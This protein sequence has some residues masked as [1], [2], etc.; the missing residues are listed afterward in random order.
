MELNLYALKTFKEVVDQQGFSH[1]AKVLFL[2]QPAV[3][4]Q[5][6]SLESYFQTP[7]LIRGHA[8]K[9]QMTQEGEILYEYASRLE[10]IQHELSKRM[11]KT[12]NTKMTTLSLGLC[13]IGG[14]CFFPEL[15]KS[16]QLQ[17]PDIR[18]S[19]NVLKCEK[20]VNGLLSG[21]FDLGITG[22]PIKDRNLCSINIGE[23]GLLVFMSCLNRDEREKK[24]SIHDLLNYTLVLRESGSGVYKEFTDF[25]KSERLRLKDFE[26][27]FY[28]ESNQAIKSMVKANV[29]LSVLPDFLIEEDIQKNE[30]KPVFL[31]EGI[32]KQRFYIVYRKQ[33]DVSEAMMLAIAFITDAI[34][35]SIQDSQTNFQ[36]END[37]TL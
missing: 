13:Y 12:L 19:L 5:I 35:S 24:L 22:L 18:L 23:V 7:L 25:L 11:S 16:F 10:E 32:L 9:I 30:V 28:S 14:E 27:V 1:A 4:L 20:I 21:V 34:A 3:S 15:L 26:H 2:T 29:G 33:E 17:H 8:G 31:Q 6:Q 36:K 37:I